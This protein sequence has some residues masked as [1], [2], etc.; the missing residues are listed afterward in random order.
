MQ[1]N[2]TE[3]VHAFIFF[4]SHVSISVNMNKGAEKNSCLIKDD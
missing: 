2:Q 1:F 3:Q 4:N